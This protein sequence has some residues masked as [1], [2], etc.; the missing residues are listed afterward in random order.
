MNGKVPMLR[1]AEEFPFHEPER[2]APSRQVAV[3]A[4]HRAEA[5][6]GAPMLRRFM[7]AMRGKKTVEAPH[8][9]LGTSNIEHPTSNRQSMAQFETIGCSKVDSWLLDVFLRF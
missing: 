2:R 8:E 1:C 6:L 4:H 9:P 7:V 3:Q 5:A